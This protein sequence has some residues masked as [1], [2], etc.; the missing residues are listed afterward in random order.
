MKNG[1]PQG[2]FLGPLFFTLYINDL[3]VCIADEAHIVM[4]AD[5]C[6]LVI[7][8]KDRSALEEKNVN[9]VKL[10]HNWFECNNLK[11]NLTKSCLMH[12]RINHLTRNIW[13]LNLHDAA[14]KDIQI[15]DSIKFLGVH[16]DSYLTWNVHIYELSLKLKK[17]V[18][19]EKKCEKL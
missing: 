3:P 2:S 5:D 6:A 18:F 4:F 1:V 14:C 17:S 16:V 11:M 13:N 12:I 15:I 10:L 19:D 7:S 9:V 8:D